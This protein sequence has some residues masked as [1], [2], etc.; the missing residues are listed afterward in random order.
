MKFLRF[1]LTKAFLNKINK[2]KLFYNKTVEILQFKLSQPKIK[3]ILILN[4]Q[5]I[6]FL[7]YIL[8]LLLNLKSF[9]MCLDFTTAQQRFLV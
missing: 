4:N 7:Y 3:I 8:L 9:K 6:L 2:V 5:I 1:P